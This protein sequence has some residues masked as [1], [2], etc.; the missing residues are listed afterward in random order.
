MSARC[1]SNEISQIIG[2]LEGRKAKEGQ[3]LSVMKEMKSLKCI[4]R[5][6]RS[7]YYTVTDKETWEYFYERY[8]NIIDNKKIEDINRLKYEASEY[9][10]RYSGG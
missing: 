1:T 6:A 3:G 9:K 4:R 2:F 8:K 5:H 10:A 7:C